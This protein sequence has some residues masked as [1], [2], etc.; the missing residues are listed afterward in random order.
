MIT[1]PKFR[2]A[3]KQNIRT[4]AL[5]SENQTYTFKMQYAYDSYNRIRLSHLRSYIASGTKMQDITYTY[6]SASNITHISNS[7]GS[8]SGLGG[9]YEGDYTY[10]NL[11]RLVAANGYWKNSNMVTLKCW[12]NEE[13]TKVLLSLMANLKKIQ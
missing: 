9:R 10:D 4:F 12:T 1:I 3:S 6:D 7:A 8:V 2:T 5:P 13:N 11:Y